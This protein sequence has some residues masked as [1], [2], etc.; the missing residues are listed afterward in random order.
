MSY[1]LGH[2]TWCCLCCGQLSRAERGSGGSSQAWIPGWSPGRQGRAR[3]RGG[4]GE[5]SREEAR[6]LPSPQLGPQEFLP[7]SLARGPGLLAPGPSEGLWSISLLPGQT[8]SDAPSLLESD[9]SL[10]TIIWLQ[11]L[12]SL[13]S[14]PSAL[15]PPVLW[16]EQ[17]LCNNG[18]VRV[19]FSA[20]P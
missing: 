16:H 12:S 17:L 9:Y 13:F 8:V 20:L 10:R 18:R 1:L 14:S 3:A 6:T 7:S 19:D 11:L 15:P 5:V 2:H 4:G